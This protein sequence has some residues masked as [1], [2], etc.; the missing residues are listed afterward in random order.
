[1]TFPG[2]LGGVR[3]ACHFIATLP[4]SILIYLKN[5]TRSETLSIPHMSRISYSIIVRCLSE[6]G[7]VIRQFL[8]DYGSEGERTVFLVLARRLPMPEM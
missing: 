2:T 3:T 5:F 4:A 1:M 6:K 7:I 8:A